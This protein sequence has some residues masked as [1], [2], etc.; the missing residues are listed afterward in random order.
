MQGL[1][2]RGVD[3]TRIVWVRPNRKTQENLLDPEADKESVFPDELGRDPYLA[4][5]MLKEVRDQGINIVEDLDLTDF[6]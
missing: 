2:Q 4:E 6:D 3:S 1:I 5:Y